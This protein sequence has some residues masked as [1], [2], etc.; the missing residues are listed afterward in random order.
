MGTPRGD[1]LL[2]AKLAAVLP[3][4]DERQ[5]RLLLGAE[6]ISLGRGGVTL[7]AA[8]AGVGRVMV[9]RG[10]AEVRA[11]LASDG[12]G[13]AADRGR[14]RKPGGGRKPLTVTDPGLMGALEALVD[15]QTRRGPDVAVAVDDD[16][17]HR[18]W[19]RP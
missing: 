5:R 19:P 4:L 18:T 16:V 12:A 3:V 15:P 2:V 14:V 10:V 17:D 7:V 13:I 8:A 1:E 9:T 6:A 11:G